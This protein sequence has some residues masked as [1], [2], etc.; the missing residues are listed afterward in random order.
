[1]M[2]DR[3]DVSAWERLRTL[4]LA[5]LADA[6]DA[7]G[8]TL[9]EERDQPEAF[10][11][12]RLL[13]ADATTLIRNQLLDVRDRCNLFASLRGLLAPAHLIE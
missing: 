11:R 1:M 12:R 6:P 9:A 13:R 8:S 5:A 2:I 4:R 10:W 3:P 7:F